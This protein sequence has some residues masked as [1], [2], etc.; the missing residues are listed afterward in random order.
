MLRCELIDWLEVQYSIQVESVATLLDPIYD[1]GIGAYYRDFIE[2]IERASLR[3]EGLQ[4]TTSALASA[5]SAAAAMAA[6]VEAAS[7]GGAACAAAT[8]DFDRVAPTQM[9]NL[10]TGEELSFA[11]VLS[12]EDDLMA[13]HHEVFGRSPDKGTLASY[14]LRLLRQVP[15]YESSVIFLD[16]NT[17]NLEQ[18]SAA[19]VEAGVPCHAVHVVVESMVDEAA[20]SEALRR[21][22]AALLAAMPTPTPTVTPRAR[23]SR[24]RL[25]SKQD[26]KR[27]LLS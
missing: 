16:D 25:S 26:L 19:C 12:L 5:I 24:R 20:Y 10:G 2:P 11:E 27:C 3:A 4:P 8:V 6:A 22:G 1:R 15:P 21:S 17:H 7:A 18:V 13:R 9:I 23:R 14:C